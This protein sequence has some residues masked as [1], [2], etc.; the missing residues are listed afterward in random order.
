MVVMPRSWQWCGKGA[1][2]HVAQQLL[3]GCG[4]QRCCAAAT[5]CTCSHR[6]AVDLPVGMYQLLY[7]VGC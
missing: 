5:C 1:G 3:C 6:R 4:R 2:A 7:A